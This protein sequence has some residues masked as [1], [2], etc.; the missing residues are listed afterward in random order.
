MQDK[1]P[2][3]FP[4]MKLVAIA[5]VAGLIAG[6]VAVYMKETADGNGNDQVATSD[7][8]PAAAAIARL[9]P[10]ATGQVAAFVPAA[11]PQALTLP[12]FKNAAGKDITLADFPG[13]VQLVNLWA[14]W[15][16]PCRE[17]MPALN[18]LEKAL[19]GEKFQ[20]TA[21]NLDTGDDTKPKEFLKEIAV[22]ALALY[23][24]PTLSSFNAL[25][26]AGVAMGLPATVLVDGKGC[27]LGAMNGPAAWESDDAKALIK[28]AIGEGA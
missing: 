23:H 8:A 10:F 19:G 6:G 11:T 25:K 3:L 2:S 20:V 15:C 16:V 26:K 18:A 21:I 28:A 17:E 27:M 24:D 13:R 9:T 5:A 7:C 1:K 14:T 12:P 22:D 4:S